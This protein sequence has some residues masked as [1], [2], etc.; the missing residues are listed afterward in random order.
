MTICANPG[1]E[2]SLREMLADPIVQYLMARDGITRGEPDGFIDTMQ[3]KL[4]G[5]GAERRKINR[6]DHNVSVVGE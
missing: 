4:A 1:R 2:L 6:Q 5:W 3:G